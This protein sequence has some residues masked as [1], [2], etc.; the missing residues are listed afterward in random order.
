MKIYRLEFEMVDALSCP[1]FYRGENPI[2]KPQDVPDRFWHKVKTEGDNPFAQYNTLK[3][4][5]ETGE[6]LIRNVKLFE[7]EASDIEWAELP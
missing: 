1:Q 4:W 6:Q 7:G 2:C 5:A 3:R